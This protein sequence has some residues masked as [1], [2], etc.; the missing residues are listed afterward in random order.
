MT[1]T[2]APEQRPPHLFKPGQSGN[3]AGRPKGSRNKLGEAFL[4]ALSQ[5]FDEHGVKAIEAARSEDPVAYVKVVASL[6][7]KEL[8]IERSAV[9]EMSDDELARLIDLVRTEV[10]A[11]GEAGEGAGPAGG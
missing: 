4:T 1:E 11:A 6:L 10:S 3:P 9:E 5:D 8:K 7:P 2:A